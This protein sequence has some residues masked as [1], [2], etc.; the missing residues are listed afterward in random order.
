MLPENG[1]KRALR[2]LNTGRC[3]LENERGLGNGSVK[4]VWEARESTQ[5]TLS[6]SEENPWSHAH[7]TYR[8]AAMA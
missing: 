3:S 5:S 7:S 8:D 2:S 1:L 6:C 4:R